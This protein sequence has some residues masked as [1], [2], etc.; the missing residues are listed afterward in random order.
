MASRRRRAYA[1]ATLGP[2]ALFA[3]DP[4]QLAAVVQSADERTQTLLGRTAFD[5]F[6][7]RARSVFLD[8]QSRMAPPICNAVSAAFY[9][10]QLRTRASAQ[11]DTAWRQN[12]E[13]T[14]IDGHELPHQSSIVGPASGR[15]STAEPFDTGWHRPSL[16]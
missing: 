15:R 9:D 16:A 5:A 2:S 3:G 14:F 8:E 10:G 13:R 6:R 11:K 7:R 1:L 12:R 4:K